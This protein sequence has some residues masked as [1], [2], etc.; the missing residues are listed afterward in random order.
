MKKSL[1]AWIFL[2]LAALG[3]SLLQPQPKEVPPLNFPDYAPTYT[4]IPPIPADTAGP[5]IVTATPVTPEPTAAAVTLQKLGQWRQPEA[6]EAFW[7]PD[8]ARFGIVSPL[9][10]NVYRT[11]DTQKL[12][13]DAPAGKAGLFQAVSLSSNGNFV[14]N[15]N[16]GPAANILDAD[17]G[18]L[19]DRKHSLNKDCPMTT[20]LGSVY[21]S[22]GMKHMFAAGQESQKVEAPIKIYRW[23]LAP[24]GC[25]RI[26]SVSTGR[27]PALLLSPD[28]KILALSTSSGLTGRVTAWNTGSGKEICTVEGAAAAFHPN[29]RL[30]VADM[31]NKALVYWR[32]DACQVAAQVPWDTYS[33]RQAMAFTPNGK[34]LLTFRQGLQVWDANTAGLLLEKRPQEAAYEGLLRIS[35]DGKY[36]ISILNPNTANALVELWAIGDK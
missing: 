21:L 23:G 7:Y 16:V 17:N 36:L 18:K 1:A 13:S 14:V 27:F 2:L 20:V 4:P 28:Q 26:A 22:D 15:F 33:E 30:A 31:Q 19:S 32:L 6:Q 34:Y 11:A 24:Y 3:C 10:L 29:G 12:W 25:Q 5:D 9:E 35:P 8:S